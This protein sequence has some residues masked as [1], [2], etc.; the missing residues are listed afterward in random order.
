MGHQV[1]PDSHFTSEQYEYWH[2]ACQDEYAAAEAE[3]M[4]QQDRAWS[5]VL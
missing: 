3:T 1:T 2:R 4:K 5:Y